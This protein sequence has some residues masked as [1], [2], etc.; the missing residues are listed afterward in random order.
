MYSRYGLYI[1]QPIP[2]YTLFI[3]YTLLFITHYEYNKQTISTIGDTKAKRRSL[4]FWL[5][6]FQYLIF[7]AYIG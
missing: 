3:I 4:K 2:A 7:T 1:I 6:F 5:N